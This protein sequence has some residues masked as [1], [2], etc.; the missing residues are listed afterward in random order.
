MNQGNERCRAGRTRPEIR[1]EGQTFKTSSSR[2]VNR[3]QVS[4]YLGN[5]RQIILFEKDRMYKFDQKQHALRTREKSSETT[6]KQN[7]QATFWQ[8]PT[9]ISF[10]GRESNH[11]TERQDPVITEEIQITKNTRRR[12]KEPNHITRT[13]LHVNGNGR[14]C[15][16]EN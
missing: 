6:F 13:S 2:Y 12:R 7:C 11:R 16:E 10:P 15:R 14:V 1:K 4:V 9:A 3:P 8:T 5:R